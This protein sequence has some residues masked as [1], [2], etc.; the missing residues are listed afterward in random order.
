MK[1]AMTDSI[2]PTLLSPLL[3]R[4]SRGG[5]TLLR[6]R[7]FMGSMHTG[8][9]DVPQGYERMA[10][11]YAE[12]A[13][14]G[15]ALIVTGG[16]AISSEGNMYADREV[17]ATAAD[18][19][20]HRMITDAVHAEGGLIAMQLI[21]AGRYAHH[22][23]GVAPS[24][25]KSP[26]SKATPRAMS[27]EEI[28]KTLGDFSRSA[29][30][31]QDVGYDGV[32]IMGAEGYLINQ[33]AAPRSNQRTDQWGGSPE[34][35]IRFA[36]EAVR[37]VRLDTRPGFLI[38]YRLSMLDLVE[39]GC[40]WDEVLLLA[41]AVE[42]AGASIIN[43]YVGWHEARVPTIASVVPRA[44]FVSLTARLKRKLTVPIVASNRINDPVLAEDILARGDADLIS[45]ARPFLA[46]PDF[47]I[48]T[49][50]GRIDEI[51]TCIAC[52]QGCL[53]ES[54][55]RR[56]TGCLVNPMACRETELILRPCTTRRRVAVVGAGPA[57]MACAA[58]AAQRG[59]E[60]T[61]FESSPEI[62]GQFNLARLIPGKEEYAETMRYYAARL[63]RFGATSIL[64]RRVD[65][66][67]LV[68]GRF[69]VIVLATG[70]VPRIPAIAGIDHPKV[71][72]YAEV[73]AGKRN[74]GARVAIVGAGGI[75]FDVAELLS[76][77]PHPNNSDVDQFCEEW[78]VDLT[79]THRGGLAAPHPVRQR[80][81]LWLLQRKD[82]RLGIHLAK[83]T[84]W[85]RRALMVKRGV[86]LVGG[87]RYE[88]ID[89]EGLHMT[90]QGE[91]RTLDV[92]T[93]VVCAGQEPL[94]E[95]QSSLEAMGIEPVVIGGALHAAEL[96]ALRAIDEGFRFAAS[97]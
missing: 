57:G 41:K 97:I 72:S 1:C 79:V 31:A 73:I 63:R 30:L 58:T 27:V 14:G 81:G 80:R 21:H 78:G 16:L 22:P 91:P 26:L 90:V 82:E 55:S 52:N 60:V 54:F 86:H 44:A 18:A 61:L 25:I 13:R 4:D 71:A 34:N 29:K 36:T 88:R 50:Q 37:R 49:R 48:K 9:E 84:G 33:F 40:T 38:I 2:C 59:H 15:V 3:V 19:Q 89:D 56:L 51:N 74:V 64:G 75:G 92:D 85:I 96:D 47:V 39:G 5:E 93:V 45:M 6:C 42:A 12:R 10:A 8:L 35:R 69:D 17:F 68:D 83:T 94:N 28:E 43:P 62:G 53:D 77:E 95:L 65:A 46:D 23:D 76:H 11:F 7:V 20:P 66:Q 67:T 32:E 70:A 87:V 24:A